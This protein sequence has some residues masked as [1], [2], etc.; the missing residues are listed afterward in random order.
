[1]EDAKMDES[2]YDK[3]KEREIKWELPVIRPMPLFDIDK[4]RAGFEQ[5][6][7]EAKEKE[8]SDLRDQFA[9]LAMQSLLIADGTTYFEQRAKEAYDVADA[10]IKQRSLTNA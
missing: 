1:M 3:L 5:A 7:K 2:F 4:A 6:A 10:M 9:G 8:L